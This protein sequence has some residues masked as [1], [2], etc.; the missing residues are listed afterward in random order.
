M[1]ISC[2]G[3]TMKP[4]VSPPPAVPLQPLWPLKVTPLTPGLQCYYVALAFQAKISSLADEEKCFPSNLF[5]HLSN[6]RVHFVKVGPGLLFF[7]SSWCQ[8][9]DWDDRASRGC[10]YHQGGALQAHTLQTCAHV[11]NTENSS[12]AVKKRKRRN[13]CIRSGQT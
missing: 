5:S 12:V 4:S 1:I 7:V 2:A 6:Y 10:H 13:I 8:R 11:G 3:Q 9:V